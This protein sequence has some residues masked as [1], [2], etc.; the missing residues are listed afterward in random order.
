MKRLLF[1]LVGCG[2]ILA[3]AKIAGLEDSDQATET[4]STTPGNASSSGTGEIKTKEGITIK[5]AQLGLAPSGCSTPVTGMVTVINDSDDVQHYEASVPNNDVF[6]VKEGGAGD[7]KAHDTATV[8]VQAIGNKPGRQGIELAIKTKSSV[9]TVSVSVDVQGAS[10]TATPATVDFGFVRSNQTSPS[11]TVTFTNNGNVPIDVPELT[12]D[13]TRSNFA[14]PAAFPVPANGGMVQREF[15]M[16]QG[17]VGAVTANVAPAIPAEKLCGA[18]PPAL[19]LKGERVDRKVIASPASVD[20][21]SVDCNAGGGATTKPI[22]I[23]NTG[24]GASFTTNTLQRFKVTPSD[25]PIPGI[26]GTTAG[27]ATLAVSLVNAGDTPGPV[28]EKLTIHITGEEP[29]DYDV[30]LSVQAVGA[31]VAFSETAFTLTSGNSRS[32]TVS[33]SGN[34]E[35]CLGFDS[36]D[37]HFSVAGPF[38]PVAKGFSGSLKVEYSSSD[39]PHSTKV[40]A[41]PA[42]FGL[43]DIGGGNPVMCKPSPVLDVTGN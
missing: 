36:T 24:G 42:I 4:P 18:A 9:Q 32:I 35:I 29:H 3:C 7:I 16:K 22:T 27:I 30:A 43:C 15:T 14:L 31:V 8:V 28:S 41:R 20:F 12:G 38:F 2:S 11:I 6:T 34:A 1:A 40:T 25:G 37:S 33:N 21:G 23:S 13:E 10:L 39:G 19:V 26:S 5:P 17:P